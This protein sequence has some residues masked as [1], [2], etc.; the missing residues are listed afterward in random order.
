MQLLASSL[1]INHHYTIALFFLEMLS[2]EPLV[3]PHLYWHIHL[4]LTS[5]I[6]YRGLPLLV[7]EQ[8]RQTF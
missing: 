6:G 5:S 7:L 2:F 4:L 1:L 8:L 3:Y